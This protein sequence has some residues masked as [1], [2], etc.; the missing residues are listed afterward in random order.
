[1]ASSLLEA[2]AGLGEGAEEGGRP[3]GKRAGHPAIPIQAGR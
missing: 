1:M 3:E 2:L